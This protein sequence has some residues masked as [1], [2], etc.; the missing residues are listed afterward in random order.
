MKRSVP[1]AATS[2]VS[3]SSIKN[4][5][6]RRLAPD[7]LNRLLPNLDLVDL[8]QRQMLQRRGDAI[9]FAYFPETAVVSF[10][11]NLE[12]G[13]LV[14]VGMVGKEGLIGVSVILGDEVAAHDAMAQIQGK[15]LRIPWRQLRAAVQ[16]DPAL[17]IHLLRY[18]HA[19]QYQVAQ[20]AACNAMHDVEQRC[21]RWILTARDRTGADEFLLTH[22]FLAMM[23]AVRRAGVTVA[24]G[25]LEKA[26]FIR[27]RRGHITILDQGGLEEVACE[28]HRLIR[29][30]EARLLS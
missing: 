20:T 10:L 29:E 16:D 2:G 15:A 9:D 4:E 8:P 6:L 30:E 23:L 3:P 17:Q 13:G 11:V 24:A 26:G 19:F 5:L 12:E 1:V 14:E 28:C 18:I 27:N 25:L 7:Q 21:A 22:E